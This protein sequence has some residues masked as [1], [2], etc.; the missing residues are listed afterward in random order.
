MKTLFDPVFIDS[1]RLKI[2]PLASTSWEKLAAGLLYEDSW[3]ARSWNIKT[4][5]DIQKMYHNN[6]QALTSYNLGKFKE[7]TGEL[8]RQL[9]ETTADQEIRKFEKALSFYSD[10]LDETW[11]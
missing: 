9:A 8:I 4:P 5:E 1:E 10:R 11:D 3:H 2:R 6:L 7:S